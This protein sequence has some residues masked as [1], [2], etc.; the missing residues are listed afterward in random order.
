MRVPLPGSVWALAK[1][2]GVHLVSTCSPMASHRAGKRY[3][4]PDLVPAASSHVRYTDCN[5]SSA[6]GVHTDG[7]SSLRI[8][9]GEV[10]R[11]CSAA[12]TM[13]GPTCPKPNGR[14]SRRLSR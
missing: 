5:F 14:P 13:D 7:G 6:V 9:G 11:R 8:V 2:P 10:G 4:L 12:T 3:R 1:R